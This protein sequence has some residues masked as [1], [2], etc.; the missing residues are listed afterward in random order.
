MLAARLLLAS[1]ADSRWAIDECSLTA[2]NG[3]NGAPEMMKMRTSASSLRL[4][5]VCAASF[6]GS[7]THC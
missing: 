5:E 6:G 3:E 7:A 4:I 1:V 2:C